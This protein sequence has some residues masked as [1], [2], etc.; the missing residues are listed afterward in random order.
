MP[1]PRLQQRRR[2][3]APPGC[4]SGTSAGLL[5]AEGVV[6]SHDC[7]RGVARVPRR[8][9]GRLLLRLRGRGTATLTVAPPCSARDARSVRG[10]ACSRS[11]ARS[12]ASTGSLGRG[13]CF[14]LWKQR[15]HASTRISSCAHSLTAPAMQRSRARRRDEW[16]SSVGEAAGPVDSG[17]SGC[18][19]RTHSARSMLLRSAVSRGPSASVARER[20]PTPPRSSPARPWEQ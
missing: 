1:M 6:R 16:S 17:A 19:D 14:P 9:G 8:A 20:E 7:R 15:C 5:R 2:A 13:L 3:T 11:S 4:G 12:S 10:A 18:A